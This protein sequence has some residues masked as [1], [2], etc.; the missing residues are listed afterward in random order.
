MYPL[1]DIPDSSE[2]DQRT[3]KQMT[4]HKA[5]HPR[6]DVTNYMYLEKREEEDFLHCSQR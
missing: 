2:V 1:L 6:D 3:S 4:M 5:L